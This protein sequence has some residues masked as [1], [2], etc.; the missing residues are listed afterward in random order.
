MLKLKET[1]KTLSN[2][3]DAAYASSGRTN[4]AFK[5]PLSYVGTYYETVFLPQTL[6]ASPTL[7]IEMF[8]KKDIKFNLE[9]KPE[10]TQMEQ[11]EMLETYLKAI[12]KGSLED[13]SGNIKEFDAPLSAYQA[14]LAQ[15]S[16]V[17]DIQ[18]YN[19]GV[20]LNN[21]EVTRVD[22]VINGVT[23]YQYTLKDI[24]TFGYDKEKKEDVTY[25]NTVHCLFKE[26]TSEGENFFSALTDKKLSKKD[27]KKVMDTIAD[28]NITGMSIG[29]YTLQASGVDSRTLAVTSELDMQSDSDSYTVKGYSSIISIDKEQLNSLTVKRVGDYRYNIVIPTS[30]MTVTLHM[31]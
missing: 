27:S 4:H 9:L 29:G 24:Y 30:D 13:N 2:F 25:T 28:M 12:N 16:A 3:M 14:Y 18:N 8:G 26:K 15:N 23:Y 17:S 1:K 22:T 7:S 6:L 19:L 11:V 21:P 5:K 31:G 20:Y 10:P